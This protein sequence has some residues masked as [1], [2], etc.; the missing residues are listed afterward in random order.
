MYSVDQ[1]CRIDTVNTPYKLKAILENDILLSIK[2]CILI[3]WLFI[4]YQFMLIIIRV[5]MQTS[6]AATMY[7]IPNACHL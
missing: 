4:S 5:I 6:S 3:V 2:A 1:L 7:V